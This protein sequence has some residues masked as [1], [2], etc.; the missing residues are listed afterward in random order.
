M[1]R[2]EGYQT[3]VS[4]EDGTSRC[5]FQLNGAN[6][7]TPPPESAIDGFAAY[8]CGG[9]DNLAP[10]SKP[11]SDLTAGKI[12]RRLP[13]LHPYSPSLSVAGIINIDGVGT[14]SAGTSRTV[15]GL[16][17]ITPQFTHYTNYRFTVEFKRRPYFL[18]P[19]EFIARPNTTYYK[20]D[21]TDTR[22]Y[23]A[24]EWKRFALKTLTP[25]PDTVNATTGAQMRFRTNGTTLD[26][27]QFPGQ[28]WVYMQNQLLEVMWYMVPYRYFFGAAPNRPYL[29][30]FVNT[31]N[32]NAILDYG[33]GELLF[34]GAT[35]QPFQPQV[36]DTVGFLGKAFFQQQDLLCNVKLR[37]LATSRTSDDIPTGTTKGLANKNNIAAGHNLQPSF[38]DRNFHYVTTEN[39]LDKDDDTQWF[40][41]YPSFPHELFFTDPMLVQPGGAI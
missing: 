7:D 28:A 41:S 14:S 6:A 34:L 12:I 17:S 3:A 33:P 16:D 39:P 23:Y 18:L 15:L 21:G 13:K 9:V 30:R 26:G 27:T 25:L 38:T 1:A 22:V 35:P 31:V 40:A 8:L 4:A 37:W 5:V 2:E 32:Q 24:E 36:L 20:R 29:T 11:H 10:V 19:D